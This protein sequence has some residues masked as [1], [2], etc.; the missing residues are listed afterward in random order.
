MITDDPIFGRVG[1]A[2][3]NLTSKQEGAGLDGHMPIRIDGAGNRGLVEE[4]KKI[5]LLIQHD[6]GAED[7]IG[8]GLIKLLE[9]LG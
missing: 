3:P 6:G 1:T 7:S 2:L 9:G 5:Q 4:V 8:S